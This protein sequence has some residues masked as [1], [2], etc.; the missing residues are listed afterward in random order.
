MELIVLV[1]KHPNFNSCSIED[2]IGTIKIKLNLLSE[3]Y[4]CVIITVKDIQTIGK[5][6]CLI[7]I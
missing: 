5:N 7:L 3:V 2:V 1:Y 6:W 4:I